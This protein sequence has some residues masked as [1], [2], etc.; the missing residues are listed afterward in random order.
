MKRRGDRASTFR[1]GALLLA[2]ASC[3]TFTCVTNSKAQSPTPVPC[4]V[5]G[6]PEKASPPFLLSK[7]SHPPRVIACG[8]SF[9]GPFEIVA[10]P[11]VEHEWLCTV[12]L[13]EP[14][15]DS[16][17][18]P[19]FE[20]A[21]TLAPPPFSNTSELPVDGGPI[22][23]S[24][25]GWAWGNG[26]GPAYTHLEGSLSPGVARVEIRYHRPN[27]ESINRVSAT[28]AQVNGEL[29]SSLYQ[30]VPFGRFAAVLRGC[31]TT[32]RLRLVAFDAE[33]QIVGSLRGHRS[34]FG[35]QCRE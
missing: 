10:F 32:Q 34:H 26:P 6:A 12:F 5:G 18:G 1:T 4:S 25:I 16:E 19:D 11:S 30:T 28:V 13:G 9:L 21:L 14:F 27:R 7:A 20:G 23:L 22:R 15:G 33:G 17:C 35:N 29:L 31:A 2:V 8:R 24:G 3:F